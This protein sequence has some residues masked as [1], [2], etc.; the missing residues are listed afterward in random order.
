M[1]SLQSPHNVCAQDVPLQYSA[2]VDWKDAG[3]TIE[4]VV[5]MTEER[6]VPTTI[7]AQR[8]AARSLP[9]RVLG[10]I[11]NVQLD[12]LATIGERLEED[13]RLAAELLQSV[14]EPSLSRRNPT[15]NLGSVVLE[16]RVALHPHVIQPFV[17]HT[18]A[19]RPPRH[20]GWLPTREFT[21]IV[22][23][24]AD[25]L[26]LYGTD[27]REY[28][29]PALLPEVYDTSPEMRTIVSPDMVDPEVLRTHGVAA[30][31]D[32]PNE[33]PYEDRIGLRPLRIRA[34]GT[35]GVYP[36]DIIIHE[37]D[38]NTILASQHNRRLI[39]QGRIL[40]ILNDSVTTTTLTPSETQ[41]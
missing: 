32:N 7:E 23:Y 41:F 15:T 9:R 19:R 11:Y 36:T 39:E 2:G 4:T 28:A 33:T 17:Q 27:R 26:P 35:F 18:E 13:A 40:I 22:I 24:A 16:H 34:T 21:G 20:I 31:T 5:P 1:L 30:Y 12:S 38:A 14:S 8:I 25:M 29:T 6:G 10:A 3:V 37:D